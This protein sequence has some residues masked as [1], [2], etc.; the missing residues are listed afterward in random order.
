[1][2]LAWYSYSS[3]LVRMF[4]YGMCVHLLYCVQRRSAVSQQ[5]LS[6]KLVFLKASVGW[7]K[8]DVSHLTSKL[9][10][11]EHGIACT[12]DM[13][14]TDKTFMQDVLKSATPMYVVVSNKDSKKHCMNT[15]SVLSYLP[16]VVTFMCEQK[17]YAVSP[18]VFWCRCASLVYWWSLLSLTTPNP[19]LFCI[20]TWVILS[21]VYVLVLQTMIDGC[22]YIH[23]QYVHVHL[24]HSRP[25]TYLKLIM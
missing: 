24:L 2:K 4:T 25:G 15:L 3:W 8:E 17:M 5:S 11:A 10:M 18:A 7:S 21:Y 14:C 13:I 19:F 16:V 22:V 23:V 1:M 6:Y 12:E 20:I 9:C